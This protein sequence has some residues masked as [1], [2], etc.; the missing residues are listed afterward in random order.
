MGQ[1]GSG[2]RSQGSEKICVGQSMLSDYSPLRIGRRR[3]LR[4]NSLP[5]LPVSPVVILPIGST[6]LASGWPGSSAAEPPEFAPL[7]A[8]FVRPQPPKSQTDPL[9]SVISFAVLPFD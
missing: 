6:M 1:Q 3:R 8:H 2:I 5:V 4:L 9:L 7:G